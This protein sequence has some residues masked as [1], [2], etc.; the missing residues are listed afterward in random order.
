MELIVMA[1]FATF[2]GYIGYTVGKK[3]ASNVI[4]TEPKSL[5]ELE[6]ER[7]EAIERSFQNLFEYN[8]TIATKG[9]GKDGK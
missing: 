6:K 9:Y 5:T 8:E 3:E 2:T 1:I 4:K 7:Q